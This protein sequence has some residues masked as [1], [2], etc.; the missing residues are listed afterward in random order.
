MQDRGSYMDRR[1]VAHVWFS[2]E[3][4]PVVEMLNAGELIERD[5]T[6]T[7]AYCGSR[8]CA[9]A[10]AHPRVERRGARGAAPARS[11]RRSDRRRR[12]L[13]PPADRRQDRSRRRKTLGGTASRLERWS[14]PADDSSSRA[15]RSLA[16]AAGRG[17]RRRGA[18]DAA[19][20][21]RPKP[22]RKLLDIGPA[23]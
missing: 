17:R 12:A 4:L 5:E 22:L 16:A 18:R 7:D 19:A 3:Y 2:N 21:R 20:A 8:A 9:T 13:A 1:E 6:E 15:A 10:S 11:A 23:A 14:A